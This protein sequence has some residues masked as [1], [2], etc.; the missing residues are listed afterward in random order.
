MENAKEIM[1]Q[2]GKKHTQVKHVRWLRCPSSFATFEITKLS[3]HMASAKKKTD[4]GPLKS[5]K[6][7]KSKPK[8]ETK[9]L[10]LLL[11]GGFNPSEKYESQLGLLSQYME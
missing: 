9:T 2:L 4:R 11:V 6:D 5:L 1:N 3:S 8:A 7:G 10:T